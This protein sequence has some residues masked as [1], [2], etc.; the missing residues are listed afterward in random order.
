MLID[1]ELKHPIDPL[2]NIQENLIKL[3]N[4]QDAKKFKDTIILADYS[5][6]ILWNIVAHFHKK[7]EE[8]ETPSKCH[9]SILESVINLTFSETLKL[10]FIYQETKRFTEIP[11]KKH[12]ILANNYKRGIREIEQFLQ[13]AIFIGI[14]EFT[15]KGNHS[16]V[17]F[18]NHLKNQ[19]MNTC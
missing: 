16:F 15:L 9:L 1:S 12:L 18:I 3:Q 19:L 4:S 13:K 14:Y 11:N 10:L 17:D 2:K 5:L 6:I 8:W 7:Y